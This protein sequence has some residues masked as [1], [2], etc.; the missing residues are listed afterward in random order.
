MRYLILQKADFFKAQNATKSFVTRL[1][2]DLLGE[3][4]A[5][6]YLHLH[7]MVLLLQREGEGREGERRRGEMLRTI[8]SYA[9]ES[10]TKETPTVAMQTMRTKHQHIYTHK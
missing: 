3:L 7:L 9:T 8:P 1:C 4:T 10:D 2:P 6:P 5:L